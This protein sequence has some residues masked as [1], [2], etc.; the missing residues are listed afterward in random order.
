M[1]AVQTESPLRKNRVDWM[2]GFQVR[3]CCGG[4]NAPLKPPHAKERAMVAIGVILVFVVVIGA[5]NYF[6]FGRV[7]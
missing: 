2:A 5:L 7:D 1:I 4:A 6:E 3:H